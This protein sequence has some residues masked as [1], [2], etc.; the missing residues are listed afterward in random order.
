[1][2][3]GLPGLAIVA[4][5]PCRAGGE[6][7]GSAAASRR[8]SSSGRTG[9]SR[10]ISRRPQLR[11][12]APASTSRSHSRSFRPPARGPWPPLAAVVETL[13]PRRP[14]SSGRASC[15]VAEVAALGASQAGREPS[16]PTRRRSSGCRAAPVG[17]HLADAV[18]Y[19][20][21]SRLPPSEREGHR[22]RSSRRCPTW[23]RSA[24]NRRPERA[25]DR[26]CGPA[27]PLLS[28]PPGDRE[29]DSGAPAAVDPAGSRAAR[30]ARGDAD[31]LRLGG[32]STCPAADHPAAL[33]RTA[34]QRLVARDRRR[35]D[36]GPRPGEV[37]LAHHGVLLL[38]E[39]PEFQRPALEAL[40]QPLADGLVM[41]AA[42]RP[43][44][45]PGPVSAGWDDEPV[46]VR[47]A[48]RSGGELQ[49]LA[50]RLTAFRDKLRE[51][52]RPL[53]HGR[54]RAAAARARAGGY[55]RRVFVR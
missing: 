27:Q 10:S 30:S 47:R 2:Q 37:T 51:R 34:P 18:A 21:G 40:R 12:T 38:D 48:G 42:R 19:L 23:P 41:I 45:V 29:D 25:R 31:P 4:R 55:T 9:G 8:R 36:P 49:V 39:L 43:R 52:C 14:G 1:M 17:S 24:G 50:Q 26:R 13:A 3:R 32:S 7:T 33:P 35:R 22:P 28:G 44:D 15:S 11:R 20:G 53:R 54:D 5:R 46:P 16:R 6:A